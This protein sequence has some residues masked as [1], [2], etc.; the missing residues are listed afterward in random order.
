[1]H[2]D[3]IIPFFSPGL[4]SENWQKQLAQG[5]K[6]KK[7]LL[8][9]LKLENSALFTEA[10]ASELFPTVVPLSFVRKIKMATADDPLLLQV[11]AS[12]REFTP[13]EGFIDDPLAEQHQLQL[14]PNR[15]VLHKYR[16]RVLVVLTAACAINCRYCFRRHFPYGDMVRGKKDIAAIIHYL[17][18]HPAVNEVILSGGEPLLVDDLYLSELLSALCDHT[19][20]SRI[21]IH[22]RMVSVLPARITTA[23]C[24]L[25]AR[26]PLPIILVTHINH[27]QEIDNELVEQFKLLKSANVTLLNQSVLLRGVN[28]NG[29]ALV[30]LSES[31]FRAGLLPYYLHQ[32]DPTSGTAH[33][34][35]SDASARKLLKAMLAKLPGFL[36]PRLVRER[37]EFSSKIPLDLGID[38]EILKK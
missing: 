22:S 6:S 4:Q 32:L 31:L 37:A 16:S 27:A 20:I 15:P 26:L 28:D 21:R 5:I 36:V 13:V 2:N 3:A 7:Q 17:Q 19:Q 10:D 25:F 35:V 11:L 18:Q 8:H 14:N 24:R 38:S 1:M 29:D 9:H 23:L 12:S 34:N 30:Q 33:F